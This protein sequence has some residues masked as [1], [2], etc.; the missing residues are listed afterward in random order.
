[1]LARLPAQRVDVVPEVVED[2]LHFTP[3]ASGAASQQ[4]IAVVFGN[5]LGQSIFGF[6]ELV[7]G[8][9][10]LGVGKVVGLVFVGLGL[11]GLFDLV[12]FFELVGSGVV[13]TIFNAGNAGVHVA[14]VLSWLSRVLLVAAAAGQTEGH[15]EGG[16]Q[17]K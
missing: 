11:A 7:V 14:V 10:F 9:V 4:V 2:G 12:G 17:R 16:E 1:M 6:F 8:D 15:G 5:D 3:Q 13:A